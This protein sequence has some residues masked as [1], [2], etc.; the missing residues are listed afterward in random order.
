MEKVLFVIVKSFSFNNKNNSISKIKNNKTINCQLHNYKLLSVCD[1]SLKFVTTMI[2]WSMMLR[3]REIKA[4]SE[5]CPVPFTNRVKRPS[6]GTKF[7]IEF[8]FVIIWYIWIMK[9]TG[10][11]LILTIL[12]SEIIC[13]AYL[14]VDYLH[15]EERSQVYGRGVGPALQTAGPRPGQVRQ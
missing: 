5:N 14:N 4:R 3:M 15:Q 13:P 1:M 9:Y 8:C 2:P 7:L 12:Y 6:R 10:L 11:I